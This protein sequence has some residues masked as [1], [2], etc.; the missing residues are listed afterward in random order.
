MLRHPPRSTRTDTLF[1]STTLF[2]SLGDFGNR[3]VNWLDLGYRAVDGR[4]FDVGI[5]SRRSIARLRD[6]VPGRLA[7]GADES[8]NGNGAL[9]RVLP[10]ALWHRGTD[11][12]LVRDAS[13]SSLPT[14]GH[15]RSQL[16]CALYCLWARSLVR[17]SAR[18]DERRV[19]KEW[20]STGRSR[21]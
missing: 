11:A 12:E 10:L 18:S 15:L 13:L 17:Q 2:R 6:G 16:C 3:L 7:G 9:M 21:G 4:V 14:H 5:T 1:P 19:G 20:V 8:D